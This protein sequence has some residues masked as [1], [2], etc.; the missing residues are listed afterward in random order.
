MPLVPVFV[1]QEDTMKTP[2]ASFH[3]APPPTPVHAERVAGQLQLRGLAG[4]ATVPPLAHPWSGPQTWRHPQTWEM[5]PAR[6][7]THTENAARK[8]GRESGRWSKVWGGC[9]ISSF[10]REGASPL[11]ELTLGGAYFPHPHRFWG[12]AA[13]RVRGPGKGC[14]VSARRARACGC[15][16]LRQE[17]E[18]LASGEIKADRSAFAAPWEGPR[19]TGVCCGEVRQ[20]ENRVTFPRTPV[21]H[22]RGGGKVRTT[23]PPTLA[24]CAGCTP[25][26]VLAEGRPPVYERS[27]SG[28]H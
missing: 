1:T 16:G 9:L 18:V 4:E 2:K 11:P 13:Q 19:S 24:S 23:V 27:D 25:L 15:K 6:G 20:C 7:K 26:L 8:Q 17:E 21:P 28:G 3:P 10:H 5:T 14:G 12:F 22:G